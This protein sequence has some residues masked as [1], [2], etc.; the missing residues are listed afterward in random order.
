MPGSEATGGSGNMPPF[1]GAGDGADAPGTDRANS[2]V[3]P[4]ALRGMRVEKGV[5]R[6]GEPSGKVRD[7]WLDEWSPDADGV[8]YRRAARVVVFDPEGRVLLVHGHDF[9]DVD[10]SWWFTVGGGLGEEGPRE[11]AVRELR[12]ETGVSADPSRLV[13]PVLLRSDE[14]RFAA[15]TVRQ[16]EVF[17]VLAVSGEEARSA[18]PGY[19]LTAAERET[20]DEFRWWSLAEIREAEAKGETF[21]PAGLADLVET[22]WPKWDG[23]VRNVTDRALE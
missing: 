12:E 15:R 11:G 5:G 21:Y 17:F 18:R 3:N 6:A 9:D 2:V 8:P 14:F 20:L 13:G 4:P 23:I 1:E 19:D 10:H 22:W 16:D 7:S